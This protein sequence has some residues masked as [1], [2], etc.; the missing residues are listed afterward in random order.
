MKKFVYLLGLFAYVVGLVGGVGYAIF[1]KAYIIAIC[2]VFLAA[3]GFPVAKKWLY[4]LLD[5]ED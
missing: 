4:S 5:K 1:C 3:L 2:V